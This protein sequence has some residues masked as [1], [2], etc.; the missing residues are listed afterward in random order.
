MD[1]A[2]AMKNSSERARRALKR[3]RM[4]RLAPLLALHRERSAP[5]RARS[6]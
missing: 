4:H 6:A 2:A 3:V 1:I 5:P